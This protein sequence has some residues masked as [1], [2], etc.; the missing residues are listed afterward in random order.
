M[1]LLQSKNNE[2]VQ[3]GQSTS[4]PVMLASDQ[5]S[6]LIPSR[7]NLNHVEQSQATAEELLLSCARDTPR[8]E[9]LNFLTYLSTP[10]LILILLS[11][12]Y[13]PEMVLRLW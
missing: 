1:R 4:S 8:L 2:G 9:A 10:F 5:Q 13:M 11:F 7:A 6:D 3:A 12:L